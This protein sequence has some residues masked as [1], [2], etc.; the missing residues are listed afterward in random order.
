MII[1]APLAIR[2]GKRQVYPK[3]DTHRRAQERRFCCLIDSRIASP[4]SGS[5]MVVFEVIGR[6]RQPFVRAFMIAAERK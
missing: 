4:F 1:T 3:P 2:H 5:P 6:L